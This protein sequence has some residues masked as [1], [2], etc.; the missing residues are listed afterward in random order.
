MSR[1]ATIVRWFLKA[2]LVAAFIGILS[3]FFAA[4]SFA[5]A[6][7]LPSEGLVGKSRVSPRAAFRGNGEREALSFPFQN[8]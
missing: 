2:L 1:S 5:R 6:N 3:L 8:V 7:I 4:G